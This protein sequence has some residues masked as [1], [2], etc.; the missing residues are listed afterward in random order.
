LLLRLGAGAVFLAFGA[1]KF[2]SHASEVA[3]FRTYG[4]PAPDSFVYAIG[5]V[6]LVGGVLLIAGLST[7][8]VALVL[9]GDMVGAIIVSGVGH[10]ELISLTL[11][12]ALLV[13]MLS[14]L[15]IGPGRWSL[16]QR[17][18]PPGPEANA[19]PGLALS[20][21]TGKVSPGPGSIRAPGTDQGAGG[22]AP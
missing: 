17:L 2:T 9:A 14:L 1:G 15:W 13:G 12:P 10:Q 11:A 16:D 3:S 22:A 5:A 20:R 6:E 19:K 4:L 7:R 8:L 18:R 21:E